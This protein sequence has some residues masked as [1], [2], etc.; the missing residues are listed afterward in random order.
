MK[1]VVT[2]MGNPTLN[3]ELKRYTQ[4]DVVG[5]DL[6]YQE[7]VIDLLEKEPFEVLTLSGILQGQWDLLEFVDRIQKINPTLRLII[8]LDELDTN[9][10]CDLLEKDVKDI[11][12]DETVE[13]KDIVD[14]ILREEPIRM[15]I[16]S[17][18]MEDMLYYANNVVQTSQHFEHMHNFL[19]QVLIL[20]FRHHLAFA[21]QVTHSL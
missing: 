18:D 14:A 4:M 7:A 6:F 13:V 11:F 3:Q 10:K 1:R 5:D 20:H 16:G 2:A 9:L 17:G 15:L 19:L 12:A 8:V 21:M